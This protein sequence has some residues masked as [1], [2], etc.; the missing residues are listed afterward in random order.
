MQ[1]LED[2]VAELAN[3]AAFDCEWHRE[4][5]QE[6]KEKGWEN[7]IYCFCLIDNADSIEK[8][9]IDRFGGNRVLFLTSIL[10]TVE[11]YDMLVGYCIFG[12][13]DIDSDLKHLEN[14]CA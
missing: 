14:N 2:L 10:E 8:F 13:R 12:D 4:D 9:H 6:N 5:L 7:D 1:K 11:R 3:F